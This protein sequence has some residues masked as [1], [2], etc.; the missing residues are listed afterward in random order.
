MPLNIQVNKKKKISIRGG[1][2]AFVVLAIYIGFN[3]YSVSNRAKKGSDADSRDLSGNNRIEGQRPSRD[4]ESQRGQNDGPSDFSKFVDSRDVEYW[5]SRTPDDRGDLIEGLCNSN[6]TE[7]AIELILEHTNPGRE[8]EALL[9][10]LGSR[11]TSEDVD[12]LRLNQ[13]YDSLEFVS[14]RKALVSGLADA[15]GMLSYKTDVDGLE[16]FIKLTDFKKLVNSYIYVAPLLDVRVNIKDPIQ[17]ADTSLKAL[18]EIVRRDLISSK[19]ASDLYMDYIK[20]SNEPE[21]IFRQL[22][23]NNQ[24]KSYSFVSQEM[25]VEVVK[26]ASEAVGVKIAS[27]LLEKGGRDLLDSSFGVL[28]ETDP[29]ALNNWFQENKNRLTPNEGDLLSRRM[30]MKSADGGDMETAKEWTATISNSEVRRLLEDS[31]LDAEKT[32]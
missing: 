27:S 28:V 12:P 1:I 17:I 20:N 13:L 19:E 2:I 23:T 31:I 8:R 5:R 24:K 26:K 25:I 6:E 7:F 15:I 11:M 10:R 4:V 29:T 9:V 30:A 32:K 3:N 16:N 21:A 22:V 14:E 18:D